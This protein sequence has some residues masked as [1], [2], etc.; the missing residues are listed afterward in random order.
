MP[1]PADAEMMY[2]VTI[3]AKCGDIAVLSASQP[4]V[5]E[6]GA[7][8]IV[9]VRR[10]PGPQGINVMWTEYRVYPLHW[11]AWCD[12]APCWLGPGDNRGLQPTD[13]D[14]GWTP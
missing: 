5:C 4:P 10:V 14:G 6:G 1:V 2:R 13:R 8:S 3:Y 7:L 12:V 9:N 11:V